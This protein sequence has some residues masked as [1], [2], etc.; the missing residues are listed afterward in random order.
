MPII[1]SDPYLTYAPLDRIFPPLLGKEMIVYAVNKQTN[2]QVMIKRL[3]ATNRKEL[4]NNVEEIE[5][6]SK[7]QSPSVIPFIDAY[8]LPNDKEHWVFYPLPFYLFY[9]FILLF[10]FLFII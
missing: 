8:Y 5:L 3:P 1:Y 10:L 4:K 7:L 2:K 6:L 9:Y